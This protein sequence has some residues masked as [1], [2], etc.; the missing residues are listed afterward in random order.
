MRAWTASNLGDE[1]AT[2]TATRA[3]V[4]L[5]PDSAWSLYQ[6]GSALG[7][8]DPR[9]ALELLYRSA[10]LDP[11][12]AATFQ[13]IGIAHFNLGELEAALAPLRQA[14]ALD[15]LDVLAH[16]G[17]AA[18]HMRMGCAD[19]ARSELY[20]ALSID[21]WAIQPWANLTLLETGFA[22]TARAAEHVIELDPGQTGHRAVYASSL[23]NLGEFERAR[24]E[25]ALL[26]AEVPANAA[27]WQAY[28]NALANY[29][30]LRTALDAILVARSITPDD[31]GL[32]EFEAQ[33]RAALGTDG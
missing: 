8:I 25:F 28:A 24:D 32:D 18:V 29:G 2:R 9:K 6:A 30:E 20:A 10:E 22:E 14:L 11:T 13:C 4:S 15:P 27:Y 7:A 33:V 12:R 1:P 16:N 3:L 23:L 26:V 19:D 5:W 31:P 17:L 21:P